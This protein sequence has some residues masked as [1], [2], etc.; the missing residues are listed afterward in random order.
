MC[1]VSDRNFT[2]QFLRSSS[3]I[4]TSCKLRPSRSSLHTMNVSPDPSFFRHRV[5]RYVLAWRLSNLLDASFCIEALEDALS[6]GRPEIFNTDQVSQFS[7]DNFTGVVR[8]HGVAISIDGRAGFADN[9]FV[10]RLWR[11]L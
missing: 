9:I 11:S 10:E 7:D 3:M 2:R 4:M 1:S 5:S 8:A 6:Q